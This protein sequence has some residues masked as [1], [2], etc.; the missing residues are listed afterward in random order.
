M[1]KIAL[2][3]ETAPEIASGLDSGIAC[4][5]FKIKILY[6]KQKQKRKT[7]KIALEAETTTAPETVTAPGSEIVP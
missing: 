1:M 2:E 3:A 7:M 5:D 4:N 6:L